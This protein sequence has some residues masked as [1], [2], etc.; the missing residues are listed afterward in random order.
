M[1]SAE[2]YYGVPAHHRLR[3]FLCSVR[4][5]ILFF[6]F[7]GLRTPAYIASVCTFPS[8][9]RFEVPETVIL[10]VF[11]YHGTKCPPCAFSRPGA[12]LPH[13]LSLPGNSSVVNDSCSSLHVYLLFHHHV[14]LSTPTHVCLSGKNSCRMICTELHASGRRGSGKKE[15][16]AVATSKL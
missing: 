7:L 11:L 4:G 5:I 8:C 10:H 16:Q 13:L 14:I 2:D 15:S 3:V 6:H 12:P 1:A 9:L